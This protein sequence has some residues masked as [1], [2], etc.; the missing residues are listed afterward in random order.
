MEMDGT[1]H[2]TV[3]VRAP[4]ADQFWCMSRVTSA[5]SRLEITKGHSADEPPLPHRLGT[6]C[7]AL[8][9]AYRRREDTDVD[10]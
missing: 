3:Q 10:C 9:N 4:Y 6:S 1:P 8:S 7:E 2:G 5:Q